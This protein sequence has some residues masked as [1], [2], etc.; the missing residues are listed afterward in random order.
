MS[1]IVLLESGFEPVIKSILYKPISKNNKETINSILKTSE[2]LFRKIA[3][4][5]IIYIILLIIIYPYLINKEFDYL[6]TISLIIIISKN[7]CCY[8]FCSN[9]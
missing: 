7:S 2:K 6:Y 8:I 3:Y 5:F 1:F 4:I 9:Y